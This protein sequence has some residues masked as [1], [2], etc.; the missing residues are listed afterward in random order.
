MIQLRTLA[1][2]AKITRSV[3][4][5]CSLE[6]RSLLPSLTNKVRNTAYLDAAYPYSKYYN[7]FMKPEAKSS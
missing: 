5:L 7:A 1:G 6:G 3:R 4:R 2:E